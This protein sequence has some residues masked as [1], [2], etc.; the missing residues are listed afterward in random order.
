MD[1]TLR[2]TLIVALMGL[3]T[4]LPRVLPLHFDISNWPQ[5][6]RNAIEFLPVS[7][8]AAMVVSPIIDADL[9]TI[10]GAHAA[11]VAA[12]TLACAWFTRNLLLTIVI[13]TALNVAS[14]WF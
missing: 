7:L 11:G 12:A 5:F 2:L 6:W 1:E 13:G 9:N 8:I 4:Y 10:Q 3:V 14:G